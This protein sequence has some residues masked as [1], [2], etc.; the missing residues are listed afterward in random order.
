[1]MRSL[2]IRGMLVGILAGVLAFGFAK[3]FGEPQVDRAIAFE[4]QMEESKP[5]AE[6]PKGMDMSKPMDMSK[7][8][9]MTKAE[10]SEPELVSP[11]IQAGLGLLT[12]VVVFSTAFGGLFALVFGFVYGRVSHLSARPTSAILALTGFIAVYV[13]PSL[14][15]PANPPAVGLPET[16]GP[17]TALYFCLI[18]ISIAAMVLAVAIRQKL[19]EHRG[20]WNA[21]LV[22]A[23]AFLGIVVIAELLPTLN[24]VPEQ[25]PAAVLWNF[26]MASAGIQ[27]VLWTTLAIAFGAMAEPVLAEKRRD[28]ALASR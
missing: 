17:R 11:E 2:L 27:V 4:T 23:A 19:V 25:F 5:H 26:R 20:G 9:V 16:I 14:K 24:E 28:T 21:T 18:V 7:G 13:V 10:A 8:M 22:A 1:M 15:Y 12:G 6:M 3:V